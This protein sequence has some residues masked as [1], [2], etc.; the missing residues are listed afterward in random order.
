[1]LVGEGARKGEGI[2]EK[3]KTL[4]EGWSTNRRRESG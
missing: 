4:L 3:G 1:L 2:G